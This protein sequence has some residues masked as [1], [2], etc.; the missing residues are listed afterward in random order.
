MFGEYF[1]KK[2]QQKYEVREADLGEDAQL[3]KAGMKFDLRSFE[4]SNVGH[5]FI[6]NMS[7]MLGAMKMETVVLAPEFRKLPLVNIDFVAAMGKNTILAEYYDMEN[8]G[9]PQGYAE[10]L[11]EIKN[12]DR[13]IE[14]NPLGDVWYNKYLL[15]GSYRKEG[16]KLAEHFRQV[17]EKH[18]DLLMEMLEAAQPAD[19]EH[20]R[21]IALSFA[22]KLLDEGGPA[23]NSFVKLF[24]REKTEKIVKECMYGI[25]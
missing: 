6:M 3:K 22:Q 7:G 9:L 20:M 21:E 10:K 2:L 8:I 23:V 18:I 19:P 12:A 11:A 5:F 15:E 24:G 25:K 4:V 17:G 14:D 13:A 16:K 1:L